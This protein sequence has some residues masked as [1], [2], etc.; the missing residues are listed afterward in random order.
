MRPRSE[1]RPSGPITDSAESATA[2]GMDRPAPLGER[3][4]SRAD[5]PAWPPGSNGRPPPEVASTVTPTDPRVD[6]YTA[7]SGTGS[8]ATTGGGASAAG[9]SWT[10]TVVTP[11]RPKAAPTTTR[12]AF[13]LLR[14]S[15]LAPSGRSG[16][17]PGS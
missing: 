7:A 16:L 11:A 14:M 15:V 4:L 9:G 8:S 5:A 2:V 17:R 3:S 12:A 1:I 6:E 13:V 10:G